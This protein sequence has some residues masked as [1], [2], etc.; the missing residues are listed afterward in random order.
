MHVPPLAATLSD[1]MREL[2][3]AQVL[4]RRMTVPAFTTREP[5]VLTTPLNKTRITFTFDLKSHRAFDPIY[6]AVR[7]ISRRIAEK[8]EDM[9]PPLEHFSNAVPIGDKMIQYTV[10]VADLNDLARIL[11]ELEKMPPPQ[12]RKSASPR[13]P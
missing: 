10:D 9:T 11:D 13:S 1:R 6:F 7:T 5:V 2:V 3:T 8:A 12:A 4:E